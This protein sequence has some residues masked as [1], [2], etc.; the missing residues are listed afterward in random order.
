MLDWIQLE[1]KSNARIKWI[2]IARGIGILAV[3]CSHAGIGS[4]WIVPYYIPMFVLLSGMTFSMRDRIDRECLD[5]AIKIA[6]Q[7]FKYS[8]LVFLM[9]MPL[10]ILDDIEINEVGHFITINII[11]VFYARKSFYFPY[12]SGNII[13]L[14]YGNGPM[15]FL[16]FL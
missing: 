6:V 8:F 4:R 14:Q 11:G 12:D 15:W 2:D 16:P 1:K 7:Y 5:R 9:Y 10:L 3:M 13:F